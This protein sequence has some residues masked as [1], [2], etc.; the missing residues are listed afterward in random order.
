MSKPYVFH[1][2]GD[3]KF[4]HEVIWNRLGSLQATTFRNLL[5]AGAEA[6]HRS[7]SVLDVADGFRD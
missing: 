6:T 7:I 1:L 5:A 4:A 2:S 3:P